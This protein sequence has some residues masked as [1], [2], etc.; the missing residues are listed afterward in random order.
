MDQRSPSPTAR[1]FEDVYRRIDE[2]VVTGR[3]DPEDARWQILAKTVR[4]RRA[5]EAW[6][7][8]GAPRR[9]ATDL[10]R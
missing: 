9:R 2:Q 7:N 5:N 4:A 10:A 8:R 3:L 6:Q 1:R